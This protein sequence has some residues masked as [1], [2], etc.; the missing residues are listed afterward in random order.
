MAMKKWSVAIE[1]VVTTLGSIEV[2]AP[3]ENAAAHSMIDTAK[4]WTRNRTSFPRVHDVKWENEQ[5]TEFH[6]LGVVAVPDEEDVETRDICHGFVTD[7][8]GGQETLNDEKV[9]TK[10][11]AG[12]LVAI[13]REFLSRLD[14]VPLCAECVSSGNAGSAPDFIWRRA[15]DGERCGAADCDS[16]EGCENCSPDGHTGRCPRCFDATGMGC[17]HG[18]VCN[19]CEVEAEP[20]QRCKVCKSDDLSYSAR[21]SVK[22]GKVLDE[23]DQSMHC[24]ECG[25]E[26]ETEPVDGPERNRSDHSRSA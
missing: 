23:L 18:D 6:R 8:F 15:K 24:A 22:T 13:A 3:T 5:T 9:P 1:K 17:P 14:G 25:D 26:C 11:S 12:K 10:E 4:E 20:T 19:D 21:V 16:V 7:V 2:E